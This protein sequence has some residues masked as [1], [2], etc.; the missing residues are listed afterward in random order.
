MAMVI[1]LYA[2]IITNTQ[3]ITV[4]TVGNILTGQREKK[5]VMK[6]RYEKALHLACEFWG[7]GNCPLEEEFE[8]R[9]CL[10]DDCKS[11]SVKCWFNYFLEKADERSEQC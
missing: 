8:F 10:K 3:L 5:T 9:G 6:N 4:I 2:D 1:A 11:E 7:D